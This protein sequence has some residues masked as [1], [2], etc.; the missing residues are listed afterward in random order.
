V[1]VNADTV[2]D[3]VRLLHRT[4]IPTPLESGLRAAG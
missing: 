2:D 4:F 1:L 3:A